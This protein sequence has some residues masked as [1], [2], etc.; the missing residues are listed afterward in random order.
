M[1]KIRF[2]SHRSVIFT[3]GAHTLSILHTTAHCFPFSYPPWQTERGTRQRLFFLKPFEFH[4]SWKRRSIIHVTDV[5]R[6]QQSHYHTEVRWIKGTFQSMG[7]CDVQFRHLS[8][9]IIVMF[10]FD[11]KNICMNL[12]HVHGSTQLFLYNI[13]THFYIYIVIKIVISFLMY[14][15]EVVCI[16]LIKHI[17]KT[18]ILWNI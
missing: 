2:F 6:R 13:Y 14:L 17:V 10:H 7:C 9:I 1:W 12:Q 5:N 8:N 16:Y 11:S 4:E 15:I 18:A 3:L